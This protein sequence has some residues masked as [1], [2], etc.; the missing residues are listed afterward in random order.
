MGLHRKSRPCRLCGPLGARFDF[1]GFALPTI[2]TEI[3]GRYRKPFPTLKFRLTL[4]FRV[5]AFQKCLRIDRLRPV[6]PIF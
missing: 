3:T 1:V 4:Q 5:C 2:C 6:F